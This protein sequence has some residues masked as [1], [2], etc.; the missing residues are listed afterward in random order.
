MGSGSFGGQLQFWKGLIGVGRIELS[1][2][3]PG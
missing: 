2:I 1:Y 3:E